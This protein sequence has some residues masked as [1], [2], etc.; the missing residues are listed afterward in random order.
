MP[1]S[2]EPQPKESDKA[3]AAFEKCLEID[4]EYMAALYQIGR[5]AVFSGDNIDRGIEC[6]QTYLPL[7]PGEDDPSLAW[8]HYRLGMLYEKQRE[9][10][11]AEMEYDAALQL[12]P[13]HKEA[14]KA[15]KKVKRR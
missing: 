8:A 7:E 5:S 3:F 12:D 6:L 1:L 2:F 14:K 11:A 10:K 4:A 13:D 15:L 9:F